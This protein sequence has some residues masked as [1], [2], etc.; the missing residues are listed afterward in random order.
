MP[1]TPSR[2]SSIPAPSGPFE[3]L[4]RR[5]SIYGLINHLRA[6]GITINRV[7]E[8]E[9]LAQDAKPFFLE[10]QEDCADAIAQAIVTTIAVVDLEAVVIDGLLP[11]AL[12]QDTVAKIQRRFASWCL[13]GSWR[14]KSSPVRQ[15]RKRARSVQASCRSIRCS[16]RTAR[17]SPR[18]RSRKSH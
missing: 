3:M 1:V 13:W 6:N 15:A 18:R 8:L 12:L 10:W 16:L 17:F 2:L 7:R 5:A 11:R 4:L 14:R 9:P